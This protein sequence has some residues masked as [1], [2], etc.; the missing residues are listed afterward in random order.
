MLEALRSKIKK[1]DV[2]D[3]GMLKRPIRELQHA[4]DTEDTG[5]EPSVVWDIMS[6]LETIV[7]HPGTCTSQNLDHSGVPIYHATTTDTKKVQLAI[8]HANWDVIPRFPTVDQCY[9]LFMQRSEKPQGGPEFYQLANFYCRAWNFEQQ[10][11]A[12]YAQSSIH[13][14]SPSSEEEHHQSRD[15]KG[16][17]RELF[18]DLRRTVSH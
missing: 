14:P 12:E 6:H 3:D 16:W 11:I 15:T 2:E 10:K 13:I 18:S 9:K 5:D 8:D 17:S 4:V 7:H 1:A